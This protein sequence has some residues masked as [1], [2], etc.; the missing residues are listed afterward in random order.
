MKTLV[1]PAM[2]LILDFIYKEY[3]YKNNGGS[4]SVKWKLG[5]DFIKN[6]YVDNIDNMLVV[7]TDFTDYK[8]VVKIV[9]RRGEVEGDE[10]EKEK[11]KV[12]SKYDD[13]GQNKISK[14]NTDFKGG[15]NN[16]FDF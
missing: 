1:E 5:T 10:K 9:G 6:L 13:D 14:D 4:G 3:K 7:D 8:Q 16:K 15:I 12:D 2:E 11:E